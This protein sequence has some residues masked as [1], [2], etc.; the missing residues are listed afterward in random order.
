MTPSDEPLI[1]IAT[2]DDCDALAR[3]RAA[4]QATMEAENA[5]LWPMTAARREALPAFFADRVVDPEVHVLVVE[6]GHGPDARLVGTATGRIAEGRDV[7]RYGLIDDVWIDPR[8]RRRGLCGR[9]VAQLVEFFSQRG[10][11]ALSL[12]FVHG[13][14]AGAV[15]QRLGFRPAVVLANATIDG[16][17]LR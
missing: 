9:L 6:V 5:V 8:L 4:L 13:G 2:P 7:L 16:L 12:G 10:I 11:E 1:R 3:M 15:W 14:A 17:E